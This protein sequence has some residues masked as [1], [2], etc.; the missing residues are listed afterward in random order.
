[1]ES[2]LEMGTNSCLV[3]QVH[4]RC[5]GVRGEVGL[6][7]GE[8]SS[9]GLQRQLTQGTR[10]FK[11]RMPN[12]RLLVRAYCSEFRARFFTF[13]TIDGLWAMKAS[14]ARVLGEFEVF[15]VV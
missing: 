1:M 7:R 5:A 2:K 10:A 4:T 13:R 11:T 15:W 3:T 6:A 8:A 9:V 14:G 12:A